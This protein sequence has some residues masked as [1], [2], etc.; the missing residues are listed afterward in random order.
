MSFKKYKYDYIKVASVVLL[1]LIIVLGQ[2]AS[3]AAKQSFWWKFWDV[4]QIVSAI[5]IVGG[6]AFLW[7]TQPKDKNK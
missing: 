4:L 6:W 3:E 7:V 1:C 2:V 5:V